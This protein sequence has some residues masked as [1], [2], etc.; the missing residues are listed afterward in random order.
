MVSLL[1]DTSSALGCEGWPD[2]P[3]W[4]LGALA[5]GQAVGCRSSSFLSSLSPL[6]LCSLSPYQ[7]CACHAQGSPTSSALPGGHLCVAGILTL[8]PH[9]GQAARRRTAQRG[10]GESQGHHHGMAIEHGQ[11]VQPVVEGP[12]IT[13]DRPVGD[14]FECWETFLLGR[15]GCPPLR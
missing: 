13:V 9:L 2:A 10:C 1:G 6:L 7:P 12:L 11:R 3:G 5:Q 15:T 8:L 4:V 14:L